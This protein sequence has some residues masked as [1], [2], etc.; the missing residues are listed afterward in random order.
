MGAGGLAWPHRAP[1]HALAWAAPRSH[2]PL[3]PTH[4]P[5]TP[6]LQFLGLAIAP[7]LY[8]RYYVDREAQPLDDAEKLVKKYSS[9]LPGLGKK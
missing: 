5:P 1:L 8:L 3:P 2:P 6:P 4:P 9:Q 7:S